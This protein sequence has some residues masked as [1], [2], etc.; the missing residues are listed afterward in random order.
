VGF[1]FFLITPM[2]HLWAG[3]SEPHKETPQ[4]TIS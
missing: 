3:S 4:C 2:I 1:K